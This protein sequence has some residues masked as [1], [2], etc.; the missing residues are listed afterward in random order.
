M[1]DPSC[2][3]LPGSCSGDPLIGGAEER[4]FAVLGKEEEAAGVAWS[5]DVRRWRAAIYQAHAAAAAATR[6]LS[7][8]PEETHAARQRGPAAQHAGRDQR[9]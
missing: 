5:Y 8:H 1:L 9:V 3:S 6:R 7:R 4:R 2:C